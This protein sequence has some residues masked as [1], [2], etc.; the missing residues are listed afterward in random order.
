[1]A[2]DVKL[3]QHGV[4]VQANDL[5][6]PPGTPLRAVNIDY[7]RDGVAQR[8]KGFNGFYDGLPWIP[9]DLSRP[10]GTTGA[11]DAVLNRGIFEL[12]SR[13]RP[14]M[15]SGGLVFQY[16]EATSRWYSVPVNLPHRW[17]FFGDADIYVGAPQNAIGLQSSGLGRA[18][19]SNMP[20]SGIYS[21]S[22][23]SPLVWQDN[24]YVQFMLGDIAN[25]SSQAALVSATTS[26]RLYQPADVGGTY[27]SDYNAIRLVVNGSILA[28]SLTATGSV[29]GT[30]SAATFLNASWMVNVGTSL[31]VADNTNQIRKVTSGGVV[32][33]AFGSITAGD[34]DGV[35]TAARFRGISGLSYDG[36]QFLYVTESSG[37]RVRKC[38]VA[39]GS[40]T[41]FAGLLSPATAGFTNATGTSARF[42][43]PIGCEIV[44]NSLYVGDSANH[45]IRAITLSG[46][47]VTTYA[48]GNGG[49]TAG[50]VGGAAL[51]S[52]LP[53]PTLRGKYTPVYNDLTKSYLIVECV[54]SATTIDVGLVYA[55]DSSP[56]AA[57]SVFHI[58]RCPSA[59]PT[60]ASGPNKLDTIGPN[61]YA[62]AISRGL[63]VGNGVL[64]TTSERPR[65]IDAWTRFLST[66]PQPRLR[67]IG[68]L[69]PEA[70]SVTVTSGS[71]FAANTTWAYR[72]VCGLTLPDGRT[73]IGPP[74]E[75]IVCAGSTTAAVSGSITAYP[76]PGL[77]YDGLSFCQVYRTKTFANTLDPGD[78]MFLCYE[79]S[80]PYGAGLIITDQLPDAL[81][82]A[83]LVTN[84]TEGGLAATPLQPPNF[85][86]EAAA[87]QQQ[88][89]LSNY[90]PN[91][92]VRVKVLG[93]ASLVAA[94]STVTFTPASARTYTSCAITL[95][96]IAGATNPAT[97]SFQIAAGGTA[98]QNAVQTARNIVSCINRSPDAYLLVAAYDESDPGSLVVTSLYPG[99]SSS[100]LNVT[101][102]SG[103]LLPT[104]VQALLTFSTNA[105]SSFQTISSN[106]STRQI[107]AIAY[108]EQNAFDSFP[109]GNTLSVG[110][111]TESILRT[112]P[113]SDTLIV[114][115][116]DSVFRTDNSYTP[117]IYDLALSC[118]LPNSFARVN[119]QW[120]GLF[121]RG[122]VALNASQATAIGRPI[123]RDVTAQY[124]AYLSGRTSDFAS[125][126]AIDV[127]GNYLCTFNKRTYCYN[128]ISPAWSEWQVNSLVY[129]YDPAI[130]TIIS[131]NNSG[132][133]TIGAFRDSFISANDGARGVYRQRDYRRD[134]ATSPTSAYWYRNF[135]D[136]SYTFSGSLTADGLTINVAQ[137]DA[138]SNPGTVPPYHWV[139]PRGEVTNIAA[140]SAT[141]AWVFEVTQGGTTRIC[142]G[143]L[144]VTTVGSA[145]SALTMTLAASITQ[146]DAGA[147]VTVVGHAPIISRIL[148]SPTV[149][150]GTNN[151]FG[152]ILITME[153]CQ[154]GWVVGRFFGRTDFGNAN[155]LATGYYFDDKGITRAL[156]M[157]QTAAAGISSSAPLT[158]G[159]SRRFR[160]EDVQRFVVP[161]ERASGQ[162]LSFE[163][164]EGNAWQPLSVKAVTID[165]RPNDNSKVTR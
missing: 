140:G 107:N 113:I 48:G 56:T 37:N 108:S 105:A 65:V 148:Y 28:G 12:F 88:L 47:V 34:T 73:V 136:A 39:T 9:V 33:T 49:T 160:Y 93:V 130:S 71:T 30:G 111:A 81:L 116:D 16:E 135:A 133:L 153:R 101:E 158:N 131:G 91:A 19:I 69:A 102:T 117:Q 46:A 54:A 26:A 24:A 45:A 120:I 66:D 110:P 38:D 62:L 118:S 92:S 134:L 138:T 78:Q 63:D 106:V 52:Y 99:R 4:N 94:T 42:N 97:N 142:Q 139:A 14:M 150:P 41:I 70:P 132:M 121:T 25:D 18:V 36:S 152:D 8:R 23:T 89:V 119:N 64:F 126:A 161:S 143:D 32:T 154:P 128:A 75:R 44:G 137:Y 104:N 5:A 57:R 77:P 27:I 53:T 58:A 20:T 74:S 144:S 68:V 129:Q 156:L 100:V 86:N 87:F 82:G 13:D 79:A 76:S 164:W 67:S 17:T 146:F 61:A 85:A 35:G 155:E 83:E 40:V 90:I 127:T 55:E 60:S 22:I 114:V 1:M 151:N 122:F 50:M 163:W 80:M 95:T 124:G 29:D 157:G 10:L 165:N 15:V 103:G 115:K 141:F 11:E 123:D 112:L 149:V 109:G 98:A 159:L 21:G 3:V 6:I 84:Q 147:N 96:A 145:T 125:A 51:S 2:R 72:T 59:Y 162:T 31:Y 43:T 7:S